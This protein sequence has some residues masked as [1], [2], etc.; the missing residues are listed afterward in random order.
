MTYTETTHTSWFTKLKNGLVGTLIGIVLI[1]VA[2]YFLF[3]NEGRAIQT[4]RA[5]VEGAGLVVS[6]DS[7]S[8]SAANEGKLV[9]ITGPVKA[10]SMISDQQFGITADGA[11][12]ISR[13]VEMYQWE[14]KSESK[15]EKSVGGSEETTTT[16]SYSKEWSTSRNDSSNFKVPGGHEN[17][18]FAVPSSVQTVESAHVGAYRLDGGRVA[19]LGD[20]T[21]I[22]LTQADV[23]RMANSI[24]T[25]RPVKL[26]QGAVYI[27]NSA[28][29]PQIGDLRVRFERTDLAEA[30]FVGKQQGDSIVG[31]TTSNGRDVFLSAAGKKDA[32]AM[33]EQAQ[34]ENTI[35]TWV[36][37]V[38]GLVGIFI[39]FQ[40]FFG[41]FGVI[42][43]L[44]PFIGSI[45]RGGT[46]IIALV[47]TLIIGPVT[48]AIGWFA[49]RPL[50]AIGIIAGGVLIAAAVIFLRR[51]GGAVTVA[52]AEPVVL[53]RG[54]GA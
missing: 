14:E 5:L 4:Y 54:T 29:S 45:V 13:E 47:L 2:I 32:P 36:I 8:V 51:R 6:A 49:Y 50:L 28:T 17:P 10:D 25:T 20:E 1:L 24:A 41:L 9:H 7:A 23:D 15:T 18:D 53:G 12:A 3:W 16:Y 43:D 35:I 26:N 39:G 44:I 37:R 38:A 19:S 30:S 42:G 34:T 27:G 33:F 52:P 21:A 46:A 22:P 40:L 48:I 11:L 31:Y